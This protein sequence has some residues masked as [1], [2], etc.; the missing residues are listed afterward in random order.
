MLIG[1]L[2]CMLSCGSDDDNGGDS[3]LKGKWYLVSFDGSACNWG[4]YIQFSGSKMYWNKRSG[5]TRNTTYTFQ[6]TGNGFKCSNGSDSYVFSITGYAGKTM[7][8]YSSDDIVRV[9][10]R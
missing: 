2:F 6:E 1:V 3:A 4:E 9:W 5:G 10:K 8:T 7:T